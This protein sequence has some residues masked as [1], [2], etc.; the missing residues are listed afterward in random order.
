MSDPQMD[1]QPDHQ[2]PLDP[3]A[4]RI[5]ARVRWLMIISGATTLVAVAAVTSV[6]GYRVFRAEGSAAA[7]ADVTAMLPKGARVIAISAVGDR[8]VV[9]VELAGTLEARTFDA[10]TLAPAGRLRFGTEP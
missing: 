2:R 7:A 1:D 10:R 6:I 3:A 5:V 4:A 9:T 8:I